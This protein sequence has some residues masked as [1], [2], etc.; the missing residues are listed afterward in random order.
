MRVGLVL[1]VLLGMVSG[2]GATQKG[3]AG[4]STS[5]IEH[6]VVCWLKEPNNPDAV[7]AVVSA[8][9]GFRD[10]P[11]VQRVVAGPRYRAATTRPIDETTFD[12]AVVM[13]FES[14]AALRAYQAHPKHE[15]AV[16]EVLRPLSSR[17][18]IYDFVGGASVRGR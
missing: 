11:G 4:P 10:I 2:C 13:T 1:V 7:D 6:V 17:I 5:S 14:E 8:S 3:E 12:V 18:V 15:Q 16:R 9:L